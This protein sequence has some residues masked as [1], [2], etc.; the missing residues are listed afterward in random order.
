VHRE[1]ASGWLPAT[2]LATVNGNFKI[3]SVLG[4]PIVVNVSWVATLLFVT[5]VLALRFYPEVIP[6]GSPHRD[7]TG[8]HWIMALASGGAFFL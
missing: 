1:A 3:A 4:I 2:L 6:P 7:N 8:L 5:S